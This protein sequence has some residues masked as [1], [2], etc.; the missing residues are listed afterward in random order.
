M[1]KILISLL[2]VIEVYCVSCNNKTQEN[3]NADETLME[4][5]E[6]NLPDTN[7]QSFGLPLTIKVPSGASITQNAAGA[8]EIKAR[9]FMLQIAEG[10]G[11]LNMLK[12]DLKNDDVNK[13]KRVIVDEKNAL[14]YESQ[15]TTP[16]FHFMYVLTKPGTV[17]EVQDIRGYT[18]T[19]SDAELM[20]KAS[21]TIK[22]NN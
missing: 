2:I 11:D 17:Y 9:G 21:K 22:F 6:V 20:L 4:N 12:K 8:I 1:K 10:T 7:L 15:I 5:S 16:E 18:F 19:E 3:E 14:L 13:L